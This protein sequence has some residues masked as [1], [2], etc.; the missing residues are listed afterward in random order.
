[1]TQWSICRCYRSLS[2][3]SQWRPYVLHWYKIDEKITAV[4]SQFFSI[5]TWVSSKFK[6][7][8]QRWC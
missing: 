1:M 2:L 6:A 7:W 5:S 4:K 8:V 3:L